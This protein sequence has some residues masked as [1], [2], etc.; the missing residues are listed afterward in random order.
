MILLVHVLVLINTDNNMHGDE[1]KFIK[2]EQICCEELQI[3]QNSCDKK[4][5]WRD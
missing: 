1:I 2:C 4:N 5:N 3:V